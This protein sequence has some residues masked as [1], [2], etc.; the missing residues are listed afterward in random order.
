MCSVLEKGLTKALK[1]L[2]DYLNSTLPDEIDAD[3]LEEE[4]G[5]ERSFLDGSELTLAD[6]NLLPKLHIVKVKRGGGGSSSKGPVKGGNMEG[7]RN[8][9]FYD[10][11]LYFCQWIPPKISCFLIISEKQYLNSSLREGFNMASLISN[12]VLMFDGLSW[13]RVNK[14]SRRWRFVSAPPGGGQEV[15]QLRHPLR[16]VGGVAVPEERLHARR[17]HQHLRRRRR[18]RDGLHGRGAEVGQVTSG[19]RPRAEAPHKQTNG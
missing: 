10:S 8:G 2:D 1:K 11:C 6:C 9:S 13:K 15:P 17:V 4:K 7:D 16:H 12:S 19:R 3:S 14:P 18:D 5:S